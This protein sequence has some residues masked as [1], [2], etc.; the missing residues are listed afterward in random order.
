MRELR[1][2]P[3]R[4]PPRRVLRQD[5]LRRRA[6]DGSKQS[7]PALALRRRH[8]SLGV[9]FIGE[10]IRRD[11]RVDDLAGARRPP[12]LADHAG[13]LAFQL[14]LR[15]ASREAIDVAK[16]EDLLLPRDLSGKRLNL[17]RVDASRL[18][19]TTRV[20]VAEGIRAA[21]ALHDGSRS[22]FTG[23]RR[24]RDV[25]VVCP[26]L[27]APEARGRR[28][29]RYGRMRALGDG[30]RVALGDGPAGSRVISAVRV[31]RR[32]PGSRL[33]GCRGN[34]LTREGGLRLLRHAPVA[35]AARGRR[36]G[37]SPVRRGVVALA[38]ERV[39]A[40][41]L[42]LGRRDRR[43][44]RGRGRRRGLAG[45][46]RGRGEGRRLLRL[47][48]RLL[49]RGLDL[50]LG[51]G[52]GPEARVHLS[53]AVHAG[54]ADAR[55]RHLQPEVLERIGRAIRHAVAEVGRHR[56]PPGSPRGASTPS[57]L[58]PDARERRWGERHRA[59]RRRRGLPSKGR[60]PTGL[61]VS[62]G[63]VQEPPC[64]RPTSLWSPGA[65]LERCHPKLFSNGKMR[66]V[67]FLLQPT[68]KNVQILTASYS[69]SDVFARI[70]V[71]QFTCAT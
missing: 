45:E 57:F 56:P 70:P 55:E 4:V 13:V 32:L 71:G 23:I 16:G 66:L 33:P 21:G 63:R 39:S 48:L 6:K 8:R 40:E 29:A 37:W 5:P 47:L 31:E 67:P 10:G 38:R 17:P 22:G 46:R 69:F 19:R 36:R 1:P 42:R 43:R 68:E 60:L 61:R 24:R 53:R 35:S 20:F 7:V 59:I 50:R 44:R 27:H 30:R 18:E 49:L 58:N 62:R 54:T 64:A 12:A 3:R 26:R 28:R 52:P 15:L 9:A 51:G 2:Q 11:V 14:R 25:V 41:A 34:A 65:R